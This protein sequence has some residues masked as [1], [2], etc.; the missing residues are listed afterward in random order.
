MYDSSSSPQY[1][2]VKTI[3]LAIYRVTPF[4]VVY[5]R[6][7]VAEINPLQTRTLTSVHQNTPTK[8]VFHL[9]AETGTNT[10]AFALSP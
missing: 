5:L 8:R 7:I 6:E 9:G 4:I 10:S 1:N 2:V 3:L